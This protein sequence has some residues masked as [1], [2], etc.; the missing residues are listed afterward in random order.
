[1]NENR[2]VELKLETDLASIDLLNRAPILA[3]VDA[4]EQEQTSTYFDTPEQAL[5]A[6][7]LSLRV[8]KIGTRRIQTVKAESRAAAGLFAR[9]EW[10]MAIEGDQPVID[11]YDTP[12]RTLIPTL[13]QKQIAAIFHIVV[14]RQKRLITQDG[15]RIELVF[16]QGEIHAD[17]R[18][19][20]I[21]EL[22]LELKAGPPAAL[23]ALA[24]ALGAIAPVQLGILSK[25]QRGYGLLAGEG[26]KPV[27]SVSAQLT[28]NMASSEGFQLIARACIHQFRLN[29]SILGRAANPEALHQARV[30]L[31]RLRSALSIFRE[32][33]ADDSLDH[34]LT[35]LR[36]IAGELDMARDIDVLLG[37]MRNETARD[38]LQVARARAY[39]TAMAA[40]G[41]ARLR[42]LMLDLVEWLTIGR[43]LTAPA[44]RT[45]IDRRLDSFAADILGRCRRHVKRRGRHWGR[46]DDRTRHRLRIQT[47]KLRYSADFFGALFPG[48]KANRRRKAFLEALEALQTYLGDLNDQTTGA[49]LL[50]KLGIDH[51]GGDKSSRKSMLDGASEAYDALID[52]KRFWR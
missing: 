44:D 21:C 11:G 48:G 28:S 35:E 26:V 2:E 14:T 41:S 20:P 23:F 36:W 24:R 13:G 31:R 3:T 33:L 15:A 10:E 47:K 39:A 7:G 30:A 18:T 16:D 32:M 38:Q 4:E 49:A 29:Q 5:R 1:V 45:L 22:E 12:L 46:L 17:G 34:L 40:L 9:P 37:H 51:A 42:T 27:K 52:A 25:W 43:W 19:V 50:A 8:R 6:A